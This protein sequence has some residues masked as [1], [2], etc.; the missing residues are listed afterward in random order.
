MNVSVS[1]LIESVAV[2]TICELVHIVNVNEEGVI[3]PNVT[4][5]EVVGLVSTRFTHNII[6]RN[7]RVISECTSDLSRIRVGPHCLQYSTGSIRTHYTPAGIAFGLIS[8]RHSRNASVFITVGFNGS[9]GA[10]NS[11]IC[12]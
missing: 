7:S 12:E 6:A 1:S 10:E 9:R 4:L 2:D 8:A 3:L 11:I 5:C